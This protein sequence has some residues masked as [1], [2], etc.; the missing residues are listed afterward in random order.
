GLLR[1][2]GLVLPVASKVLL[3]VDQFEEV[4]TLVADEG[5]RRHFLASLVAAATEPGH[6]VRV[7]ATLRADFYDRPLRYRSLG[8]L[9]RT[10]SELV[11]PLSSDELE[12]AI[13][14]PAERVGVS[15]E[16]GL[17]PEIVSHV[18]DQPGSL[19]L[20]Q[21]TLT[22]LFT[23]RKDGAL[24]L[25]GYHRIGGV[26]G[27][28]VRRAEEI[29]RSLD[30]GGRAASRELFLRL[31]TLGEDTQG[32]RRRVPQAQVVSL[33][34]HGGSMA[35][36]MDAFGRHRLLS[37]DRDPD[38]REPTV[39]VAHEALLTA[40]GRLQGWVDSAREDLRMHRRLAAAGGEW[41]VAGRD[42]SFLLRGGR[43]D[44][45]ESWA[46]TSGLALARSEREYLE[47]SIAAREAERA[48]EEARREKE[49]ALQ[50][51]SIN[52]LRAL[53]SVLTA[54][55]LVAGGLT[56]L[57]FDQRQEA[58][59]QAARAEREARVAVARELASAAAASLNED[60]ER[61]ILLALE[62]VE[63]TRAVDGDVLKEAEEALHSA[64]QASRVV[65]SFSGLF[66][67]QF[68]PDGTR[69]ATSQ[70]DGSARIWDPLT[71]EELL[72]LTGHAARTLS[73]DWSADG[74]LL[75]TSSEDGTAKLWDAETGED[76]RSFVGHETG[77]RSPHFSPD[78]TILATT[79][80]DGTT[81][82]WDVATGEQLQVMKH[83]GGVEFSPD[84]TR[85]VVSDPPITVYDL[86]T[87][88][89]VLRVGKQ[90]SDPRDA[91][92]SGDG[93]RIAVADA[94]GFGHV[95]D[96]RS[97]AR[98]LTLVGHNERSTVGE[99][100]FS[101][102]DALLATASSDGTVRV[103]DADSGREVL[104]LPG[105]GGNVEGV[106]FSPDGTLVAGSSGS[107]AAKVWDITDAGSREL[108][109]IPGHADIVWGMGFGE[110]GSWLATGSVDGTAGIWDAETAEELV[111]LAGFDRARVED[112]AVS[113]DGT[114]VIG[115]GGD[116]TVL[117]WDSPTGTVVRELHRGG[118]ASLGARFSPDGRRVVTGDVEGNATVWEAETGTRLV[119]I[120]AHDREIFAVAFS[121][122]GERIATG[123]VDEVAKVWDAES[124]AMLAKMVRHQD[125][126]N[127]AAF[128][129]DGS[130]VFTAGEDGVLKVWDAATGRELRA[131]SG[132][133]A[134][135]MDV[136]FSPDGTRIATAGR[137]GTMR[138]W[139]PETGQELLVLAGHRS[140]VSAVAFSPKGN[141]L[142]AAGED[143]SIR[144]YTLSIEE[145]IELANDRVTRSLT[146]Q[147]C[148]QYV[149][150][151]GC[152]RKS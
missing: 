80:F 51:R 11:L 126:I 61:A 110:D 7:V 33:E 34:K 84:G 9:I 55:G 41:T 85:L 130:R 67:L 69:I 25:D 56:F 39:E 83:T 53:V 106:D 139:D 114:R 44:Q 45:I 141:R 63:A 6:R 22:E 66:G 120:D 104:A 10:G 36:V 152:A 129:P 112:L 75:A 17:V 32:T 27:A 113:P 65:S 31:V 116:G 57:A 87:G 108:L 100:V 134:G 105:L 24:T 30:D 89:P 97:G 132:H 73:V 96:A 42:P 18:A 60:P 13:T 144:L 38:S 142:A 88:E 151:D 68:S 118:A 62:A 14:N 1:A 20:L 4:F 119:V 92:W 8:E 5:R 21:Y 79:S 135:L 117:L 82:L 28:L 91:T 23:R 37:F 101:S 140:G 81:R 122:D 76:L 109:T 74:K 40:W 145:L 70:E 107:G 148:R 48:G 98:L 124:G 127:A 133:A 78:D 111:Q 54:A 137:D 19:P 103:W 26:S 86:S 131:I 94:D 99:I 64:V 149:H 143:G 90:I 52:R 138:L 123:G 12:R 47:T 29:Y 49:T 71:G 16:P 3:F 147:E 128:S 136:V 2:V 146:D 77:L 35:R 50:R 95:F 115:T 102:D 150:V 43:L 93:K 58:R 15:A 121:P 72:A 125:N 59:D 46:A